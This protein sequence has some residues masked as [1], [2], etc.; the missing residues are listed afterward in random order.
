MDDALRLWHTHPFLIGAIWMSFLLVTSI[1]Y[2]ISKKQPIVNRAPADAL[3]V[4]RWTSGGRQS[5]LIP[6]WAEHGLAVFVTRDRIDIRPH[7]P[8]N[9]FFFPMIFRNEVTIPRE[10]I[11]SIEVNQGLLGRKI[12]IHWRADN[13]SMKKF[14]LKLRDREKFMRV[15]NATQ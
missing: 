10:S 6:A 7:I 12:V 14:V 5:G 8:G 9:L 3:F 1:I 2:R 15:L 4:E 11:T 13:G